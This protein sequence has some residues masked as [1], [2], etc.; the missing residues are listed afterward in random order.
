MAKPVCY[1]CVL[2]CVYGYRM[3]KEEE[4]KEKKEEGWEGGEGMA[5]LAALFLSGLRHGL[6]EKT[7]GREDIT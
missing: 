2:S 7:G 1:V 6:E 4:G 5:V 3:R